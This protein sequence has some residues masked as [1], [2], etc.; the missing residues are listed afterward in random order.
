MSALIE[1]NI[2]PIF[3]HFAY[4]LSVTATSLYILSAI[5]P[6]SNRLPTIRHSADLILGLAV[7]SVLLTVGAGFQAYFTVGHDGPS[8]D[9]MTTHR[10]WALGA[11]ISLL[12]LAVWRWADRNSEPSLK[13]ISA[14][15]ISA[16]LFTITAWWGGNIVYGHGL[17]VKQLPIIEGIG[18]DHHGA[19]GH[20]E[21]TH[22]MPADEAL[23]LLEHGH[24][25]NG[26][27]AHGH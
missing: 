1:P 17:G 22:G 13:F 14:M 27:S 12:A 2:H 24:E 15:L 3:V 8:H 25:E 4:A 20:E 5:G 26:A 21:A 10:N 19:A 23:E 7:L 9:A 11:A 6:I 16:F 18:H